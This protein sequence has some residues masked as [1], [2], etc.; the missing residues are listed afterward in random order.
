MKLLK[1]ILFKNKGNYVKSFKNFCNKSPVDESI[2]MISPL[3]GR[4]R[5]QTN[6]LRNILSKKY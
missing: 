6:E 2:F 5:K 3:D 4:Y 1:Q